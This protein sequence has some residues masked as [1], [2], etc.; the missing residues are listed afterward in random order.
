MIINTMTNSPKVY[1]IHPS[2]LAL[3]PHYRVIRDAIAGGIAVKA[4]NTEYLP[5]PT[6]EDDCDIHSKRYKDYQLR[7]IFYNVTKRTLNGLVGQVFIKD[8]VIELPA[9]LEFLREDASDNGMGLH[10]ASKKSLE[11][12]LAYSRSGLFV[13]YPNTKGPVSKKDIEENHIRPTISIYRAE[14]VINWRTIKRGAKRL[15][16][17]VC[18]YETY[19]LGDDGFEVKDAEQYRVLRLDSEGYYHQEVWRQEE[20]NDELKTSPYSM[21]REVL[22]MNGVYRDR[23]SD[24]NKWVIHESFYPTDYAGNKF[25]EIPF[26]FIGSQNNDIYPDLPN[27][28]DLADLNIG[29]FRNSADYEECVF[30]SGQPTLA[31][32][33]LNDDWV[34]T[35][36]NGKILIGSRG[37]I[38]LPEGG[39]AK[40]LQMSDQMAHLKAMEHKERQMVAL[41]AKLVEQ[42]K[43]ERTAFEVKLEATADGSVLSNTTNNVTQAYNWAIEWCGKFVG[44]I[45]GTVEFKLNVEYD[46]VRMTSDDMQQ[47]IASWMEGMLSFKEARDKFREGGYAKEPDE[48]V[49]AEHKQ[50][51]EEEIEM[52]RKQFALEQNAKQGEGNTNGNAQEDK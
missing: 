19:A 10:Q 28:F 4:R 37:G 41:G 29:H 30:I 20:P 25:R 36:L 9:A 42:R 26:K 14:E 32:M 16:S 43:T 11:L 52:Q 48:K 7:A 17:M 35:Q 33:G 49:L 2:L 51:K 21:K 46:L 27:F 1:A 40:L 23:F 24:L 34:E 22:P 31:V 13:D 50:R 45:A 5:L 3:M 39:N 6:S 8:P 12:T 15:L 18:I 38:P 47:L 44:N